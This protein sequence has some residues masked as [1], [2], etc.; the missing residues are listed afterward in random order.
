MG[1]PGELESSGTV[2]GYGVVSQPGSVSDSGCVRSEV[3]ER[4]V[5]TAGAVGSE[6]S[7]LGME[8]DS[9]GVSAGTTVAA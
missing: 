2:L 8:G 7:S 4:R 9:P 1:G 6:V 3:E 5:T